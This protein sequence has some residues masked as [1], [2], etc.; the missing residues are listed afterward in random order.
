MDNQGWDI[1]KYGDNLYYLIINGKKIA[2]MFVGYYK[3]KEEVYTIDEEEN[4]FD[5][6]VLKRELID[7][8]DILFAIKKIEAEFHSLRGIDE[9][10]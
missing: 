7:P 10:T 3:D 2:R 4:R 5:P 8:E 1:I 9:K 6:E